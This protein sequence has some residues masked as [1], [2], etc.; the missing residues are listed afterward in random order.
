MSTQ[1]RVKWLS[2]THLTQIVPGVRATRL[3]QGPWEQHGSWRT[4][5]HTHSSPGKWLS[6]PFSFSIVFLP[7]VLHC[8][9]LLVKLAILRNIPRTNRTF[10]PLCVCDGDTAI[11][12]KHVAYVLGGRVGV[13]ETHCCSLETWLL[14]LFLF[15]INIYSCP[16]VLTRE[17]NRNLNAPIFHCRNQ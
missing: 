10:S 4:R 2:Q 3:R 5:N 9:I 17:N 12:H 8:C 6:S 16:P 7:E 13:S 1:E 11:C 14:L 15:L